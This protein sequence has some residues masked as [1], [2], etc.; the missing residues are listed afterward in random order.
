MG[1]LDELLQGCSDHTSGLTSRR[2]LA[3]APPFAQ[4]QGLGQL[5][6][7]FQSESWSQGIRKF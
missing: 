6:G 5:I 3:F 7:F 2:Q 4:E 1:A